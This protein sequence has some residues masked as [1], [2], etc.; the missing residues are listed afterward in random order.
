[1]AG[2]AADEDLAVG[3]GAAGLCCGGNPARAEALLNVSYDPT[4]ELYREIDLPFALPTAVAGIALTALSAPNGVFGSLAAGIGI[5]PLLISFAMLM[6]I[7]L[8][9]IRNRRRIGYVRGKRFAPPAFRPATDELPLVRRVMIGLAVAGGGGPVPCAAGEPFGALAAGVCKELRQGLRDIHDETGLTTVFVTHDQE[10]AMELADLLV[11][12][13]MGRI[14]QIGKPADIRSR[15]ASVFVR[16]FITASS[17]P[18]CG[19]LPV[20]RKRA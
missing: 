10:E 13:P 9:Q 4:R 15:P 6:A 14:E 12:M 8:V 17:P 5:A 1:M 16:D 3:D 19:A 7:H 11:V 2:G 18:W 20:A